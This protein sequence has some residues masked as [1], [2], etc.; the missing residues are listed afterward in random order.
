MGFLDKAKQAAQDAS[1][2]AKEGVA[3]VQTKRD[4]GKAYTELGEK[5]YELA[6]SGEL[7]SPELTDLVNRINALKAQIDESGEPAMAGTAA[8]TTAYTEPPPSDAP[9]AMPS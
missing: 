3:D 9:P 4:L 6:Q 1:A 8:G 5:T 7:T 2:K